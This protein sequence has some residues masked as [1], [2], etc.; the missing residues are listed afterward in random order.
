MKEIE[1]RG[2]AIFPIEKRYMISKQDIE[3]ILD[4]IPTIC[5]DL[6]ITFHPAETASDLSNSLYDLAQGVIRATKKVYGF[7]RQRAKVCHRYPP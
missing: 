4:G 2:K 3:G 1:P 6:E 7:K 5:P